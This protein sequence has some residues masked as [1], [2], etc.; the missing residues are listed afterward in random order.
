MRIFYIILAICLFV[1]ADNF[2]S[3][4]ILKLN[5]PFVVLGEMDKA[6]DEDYINAVK[7]ACNAQIVQYFYKENIIKFFKKA[8]EYDH[9]PLAEYCTYPCEITGKVKLDSI[10]Y[11]FELNEGGFATL[12]GRD[13]ERYFGDE[14]LYGECGI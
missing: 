12:K 7:E 10:I 1:Y 11:D 5:K 4:A 14:A 2:K 9:I 6:S 13:K 3:V 8:K